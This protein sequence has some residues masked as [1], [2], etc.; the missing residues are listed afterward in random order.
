MLLQRAMHREVSGQLPI[1][2]PPDESGGSG[3]RQLA[4]LRYLDRVVR[5]VALLI[6]EKIPSSGW[7]PAVR[8]SFRF[9]ILT[10]MA[11]A[12]LLTVA[13]MSLVFGILSAQDK[14]S[15]I[16]QRFLAVAK[17]ISGANFPL[18][19]GVLQQISQLVDA[20][21]M[22]EQ[23]DGTV[24]SSTS[25]G[26]P[27]IPVDESTISLPRGDQVSQVSSAGF[28]RT[29]VHVQSPQSGQLL[30]LHLYFPESEFARQRWQAVFPAVVVGGIAICCSL[31][32]SVWLSNS[33]GRPV[34]SLRK[35][36]E[37]IAKGDFR[38]MAVSER[39]DELRDLE[40]AVNTMAL[41]L[42]DFEKEIRQTERLKV[43]GLMGGGLAH[44]LRN[45]ATGARLAI[46]IH[47]EKCR[48]PGLDESL[49]VAD[50]QIKLM[51]KHVKSFLSLSVEEK[52]SPRP[53][54]LKLLIKTVVSTL[55]PVAGHAGVSVSTSVADLPLITADS[56]AIEQ[57]LFN[58]LLNGIEA[59]S[60]S[61]HNDPA[62]AGSGEVHLTARIEPC[63]RVQLEFSDN[64]PGPAPEF[65][66]TIFEPFVTTKPNGIG[67][68]LSIVRR[69]VDQ[70]QGQ[71]AWHRENGRTVF[72]VELPT[73][74]L[75][76]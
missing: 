20:E 4:L 62:G 10:T 8:R 43:L 5:L 49:A 2:A 23:P 61:A 54:D 55:K 64:G 32:F 27:R 73:V 39:N 18:T 40:I 7:S 70:H 31:A 24:L 47:R 12:M 15:E 26:L 52:F 16:E 66:N 48:Q 57:L 1:A 59:A 60:V 11:T 25:G 13:V 75:Q 45:A 41:Q 22:L 30:Y 63:D 69:V 42:A 19:A 21:L 3:T 53:L 36:T 33:F 35:R 68:G 50:R 14:K 6:P 56:D 72:V 71:I 37:V 34:A 38:P 67:L 74:A 29:T 51:E 65:S 58:L 44:E 17:T 9:R 76:N 46:G 28:L